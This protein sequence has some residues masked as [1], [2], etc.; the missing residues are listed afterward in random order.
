[1]PAVPAPSLPGP[2]VGPG[3]DRLQPSAA[4]ADRDADTPT[5]CQRIGRPLVPLALCLAGGM[6]LCAAHAEWGAVAGLAAGIAVLGVGRSILRG[7]PAHPGPSLVL[8]AALGYLALLPW[9]KPL[10]SS[11]HVAHFPDTPVSVRARVV[12]MADGPPA[13]QRLIAAVEAWRA[14]DDWRTARGRIRLT[15]LNDHGHAPL[16]EGTRIEFR[17]RL[18]DVRNFDNPGGFDYRRYLALQDIHRTAFV[19]LGRVQRL[20]LAADT[21]RQAFVARLRARQVAALDRRVPDPEAAAVLKALVLGVRGAMDADLRRVFQDTGVAH[22]LAISGLHVSI[23]TLVVVLLARGSL[24]YCP[25]LRRHGRVREAAALM[26]LGPMLFYG[27]LAGLAPAT[28]RAMVMVAGGLAAV[29][30]RRSGDGLNFLALAAM[31]LLLFHPPMVVSTSF[32]L[33]FT[34]VAAIILGM[35]A[36]PAISRPGARSPQGAVL[37]RIRTF[38]LITLL[39]FFGTLPLILLTFSRVS[40]VSLLGNAVGVPLIGFVAVPLGLLAT[41]L[42]GIS[43]WAAVVV[44]QAAAGAITLAL[45]VLRF[46][47]DWPWAAVNTFRPTAVEVA[48]YYGLLGSVM[49]RRRV[50]AARLWLVLILATMGLDGLYWAHRR[51]WHGDLKV[52]VVDVGQ[53]NATLLELPRGGI[54]MVDGGGMA[55]ND[56]FDMGERVVAPFLRSRKILTV[57]TL[58]LSHA[59]SDHMNGLFYLAEHFHVRTLLANGE[60]VDS[61]TCRAFEEL[62]RRRG[63]HQLR[64]EDLPPHLRVHGVDLEI[65]NPPPGFRRPPLLR[66]WRDLNNNSLALRIVFDGQSILLPGDIKAQAEQEMVARW[67]PSLASAVLV[68]PHHGSRSS[69]TTAFLEAVD[70]RAVVISAGYRNRYGFPHPE[71]VSR[72][73]RRNAHLFRTDRD[74]AVEI[75]ITGGVARVL[76][77]NGRRLVLPPPF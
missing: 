18:R 56:G 37:A 2:G 61:P 24:S 74:G 20:T 65:K 57:D 41:A 51:F 21:D 35:Q 55:G 15:V 59:N 13:R 32:Q 34:A 16:T 38:L 71:V 39:A 70:P 6:G 28:Q 50:R 17:S 1:M 44:L 22:L 63:I 72:Y 29:C 58:V 77:R 3:N 46:L 5:G 60:M 36:L 48:L 25:F 23:V 30:L 33:S 19:D 67:G 76:A 10:L 62:L 9:M 11:A 49:L 45:Q 31:V 40:L 4:F 43:E 52:T 26:A 47:A 68:A 27:V 75:T 64:F 69:S 12:G 7:R 8:F 53:G 73:R 54:L 14:E 42:G 66:G